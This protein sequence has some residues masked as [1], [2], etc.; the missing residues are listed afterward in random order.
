MSDSIPSSDPKAHVAVFVDFDSLARCVSPAGEPWNSGE[1]A[2]AILRYAAGVGKITLARGY[3][4]WSRRGD[5]ARTVQA[6]RVVPVLCPTGPEGEDRA[7][8]RLTVDALE[9]VYAGGEPDAVV[10]VTAD[11][12]LLPLI[13]ALRADGADVVLVSP[14][15]AA[16]DDLRSEVDVHATLGDVL[17][18]AVGPA[19]SARPAA[20][21]VDDEAEEVEA[22]DGGESMEA[23]A[24]PAPARATARRTAARRS[25]FE[26]P[27]RGAEGP[28]GLDRGA[29]R[30]FEGPSSFERGPRRGFE[31]PT[32]S[33]R[34]GPDR[35]GFERGARGSSSAPSTFERYDWSGF[36]RLIDE[37]E[38]R[39]P[40]VGVRYLVN[41]VLGPRNCGI[42]EPRLK[43]DLINRAVDEGHIEMFD[44]GNVEGRGDPVTACRLVRGSPAVVGVLG[45]ATVT[46]NVAESSDAFTPIDAPRDGGR[47]PDARSGG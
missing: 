38:H 29:R 23:D 13:H 22:S 1:L 39:L 25:S 27:R 34:G 30:G 10:L 26:A 6:A 44:V 17:G 20:L 4:D 18:G 11:G 15:A 16:V 3:A 45:G 9:Q 14:S 41:K 7:P 47:G 2:A 46:P 21:S 12:R 40:F 33:D 35:G 8:F 19:S 42:D 24:S 37:L 32:G 28:I 43:R 36:I 31:G 5:E